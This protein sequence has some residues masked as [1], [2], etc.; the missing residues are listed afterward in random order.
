MH[1][2]LNP[3][4]HLKICAVARF[5]AQKFILALGTLEQR[6]NF[7]FMRL[8]LKLILEP[9]VRVTCHIAQVTS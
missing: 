2:L 5:L 7:F 3:Y 9:G 1:I 4:D 6:V 8:C